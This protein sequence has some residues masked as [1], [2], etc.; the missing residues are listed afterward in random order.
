MISEKEFLLK[1][2]QIINGIDI[3]INAPLDT[4]EEWDS[5]AT[6]NFMC[7]FSLEGKEIMDSLNKAKKVEDLYRI[8]NGEKSEKE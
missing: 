8:V 1:M 3:L 5:L 4:L 2:K 6:V 7:A